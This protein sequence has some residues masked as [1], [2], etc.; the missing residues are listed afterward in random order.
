MDSAYCNR[1]ALNYDK[2]IFDVSVQ[3]RAG[4]ILQRLDHFSN[5]SDISTKN[6]SLPAVDLA[7]CDNTLLTPSLTHRIQMLRTISKALL[8]K[9]HLILVV[10]ALESALLTNARL[11]E[12]NLTSRV[13]P[14]LA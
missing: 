11:I 12:W 13:K 4:L 8:A 5:Q 3:D 1:V 2:E 6:T 10:P 7:L 14:A 9:G